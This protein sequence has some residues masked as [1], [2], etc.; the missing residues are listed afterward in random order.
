MQRLRTR[1]R[2]FDLLPHVAGA[3]AFAPYRLH[4]CCFAPRHRQLCSEAGGLSDRLYRGERCRLVRLEPI[5]QTEL[6][7]GSF[8]CLSLPS[9]SWLSAVSARCTDHLRVILVLLVSTRAAPHPPMPCRPDQKLQAEATTRRS[10]ESIDGRGVLFCGGQ[11]FDRY[12]EGLLP[13]C[14]RW[15]D[16]DTPRIVPEPDTSLPF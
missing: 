13:T 12:F 14:N 1:A 11:Y 6:L 2:K 15:R 10:P 3:Q 5:V 8:S 4:A 16:F 9:A 7:R